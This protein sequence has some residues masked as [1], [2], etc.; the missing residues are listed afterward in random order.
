MKIYDLTFSLVTPAKEEE[1]P[2][3]DS[4]DQAPSQMFMFDASG[5]GPETDLT[6]ETS[7]PSRGLLITRLGKGFKF[8]YAGLQEPTKRIGRRLVNLEA[9]DEVVAVK[10]EDRELLAVANDSGNLLI[11][12]VDQ[13]PILAGAG[14]GVRMMKLPAGSQVINMELVSP[15]D[16]VHIKPKRGKDKKIKVADIPIRNRATSGKKICS[17]ILEVAFEG[18]SKGQIQ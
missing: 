16:Y 15:G 5:S 4:R 14:K 11:L 2:V 3:R 10:P 18:S 1:V 7:L 13:V 6:R 17:G 8:E 12:P 9:N